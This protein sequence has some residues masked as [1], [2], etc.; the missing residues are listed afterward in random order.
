MDLTWAWKGAL[1]YDPISLAL[2]PPIY[3]PL[4]EGIPTLTSS[5]AESNMDV[6]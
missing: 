2:L 4:A 3:I 1:S 6:V 5:T